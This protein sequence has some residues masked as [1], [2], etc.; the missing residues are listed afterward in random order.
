MQRGIIENIAAK[1]KKTKHIQCILTKRI[2]GYSLQ[3]FTNTEQAC[4]LTFLTA[5]LRV[6]FV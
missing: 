3:I 5:R 1:T 6:D 2:S 4:C